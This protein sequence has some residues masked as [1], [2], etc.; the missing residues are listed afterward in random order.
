MPPL[1]PQR[2]HWCLLHPL[3]GLS[4][5]QINPFRLEVCTYYNLLSAITSLVV[6][7]VKLKVLPLFD[8]W[9]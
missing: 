4:R 2:Q 3:R 1:L 5:S 8:G 7:L 9:N 6:G